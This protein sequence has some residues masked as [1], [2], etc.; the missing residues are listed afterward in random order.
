VDFVASP[1]NSLSMALDSGVSDPPP[2]EELSSFAMVLIPLAQSEVA[3]RLAR[4]YDSSLWA[5]G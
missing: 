1:S 3:S 4:L 5:G 2:E